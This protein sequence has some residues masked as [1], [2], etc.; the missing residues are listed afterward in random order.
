VTD[1]GC[2][3][4]L[5][6]TDL[7][8]DNVLA[9]GREP[10]LAIDP[11]PLAGHPGFEVQPLLRNR[12][13]ELGTGSTFR[14]MVRRRVEVVTEAAGTD[15]DEALAWTYVAT[16]IQAGWAAHD[17]DGDDVTFSV[18]LLKALDG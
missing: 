6:H 4:T 11:A 7:H 10:W 9:A 16:A 2:D 12:R 14:W 8:Y 13:Q 5:L 15:E 17:G 18:A 1:P 3:A